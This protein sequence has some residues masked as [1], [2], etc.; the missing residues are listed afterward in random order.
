MP[1]ASSLP[2]R[3][4]PLFAGESAQSIDYHL[5]DDAPLLTAE[6][7]FQTMVW[8]HGQTTELLRLGTLKPGEEL[9]GVTPDLVY[10]KTNTGRTILL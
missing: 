4:I 9:V 6:S 8:L 5:A 3:R 7:G 1:H 10:G 2:P